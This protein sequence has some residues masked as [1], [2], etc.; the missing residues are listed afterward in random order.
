MGWKPKPQ[1]IAEKA[2][3]SSSIIFQSTGPTTAGGTATVTWQ[4]SSVLSGMSLSSFVES[5]TYDSG[6]LITSPIVTAKNRSTF[7]TT[8]CELGSKSLRPSNQYPTL[9]FENS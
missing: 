8:P 1:D 4:R 5:S 6:L 2:A 3:L 9:L 7:Q